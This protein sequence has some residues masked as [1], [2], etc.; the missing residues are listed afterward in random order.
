MTPVLSPG[1]RIDGGS[2]LLRM[3][4]SGAGPATT[5]TTDFR[6]STWL[7]SRGDDSSMRYWAQRRWRRSHAAEAADYPSRPIRLVLPVWSRRSGGRD[8]ASLG[9]QMSSQ[10]GPTFVENIGGAG[11]AIGTT[12][13]ARDAP[14]GYSLLLGNGSTQVIIPL[15]TEIPAIPSATSAPSIA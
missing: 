5:V 6:N 1:W 10:L 13:V 14:D 15:T 4:G 7:P 11:G 2:R 8:R 12:A 3:D 9:G